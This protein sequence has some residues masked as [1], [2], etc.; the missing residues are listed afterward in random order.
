MEVERINAQTAFI[1]LPVEVEDEDAPKLKQILQIL[2]EQEVQFIQVDFTVTEKLRNPCLGILLLYHKK[3][4]ERGGKST[5]VNVKSHRLKHVFDMIDLRRV[6]TIEVS[7]LGKYR[8][9]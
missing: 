2:Y 7:Q 5:F 8:H 3:L 6:I 9:D 1:H 4:T